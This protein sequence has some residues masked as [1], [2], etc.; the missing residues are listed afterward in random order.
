LYSTP[1]SELSRRDKPDLWVGKHSGLM[2]CKSPFQAFQRPLPRA[3]PG[4]DP[5]AAL[6]WRP[7]A[8]AAELFCMLM[9]LMNGFIM[10]RRKIPSIL[11]YCVERRKQERGKGSTEQS[12]RPLDV[13]VCRCARCGYSQVESLQGRL[14]LSIGTRSFVKSGFR[15]DWYS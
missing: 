12:R 11:G 14:V 5:T 3:S 8:T 15:R 2:P 4:Q 9:T 13:G 6:Q 7:R 10:V 1:E